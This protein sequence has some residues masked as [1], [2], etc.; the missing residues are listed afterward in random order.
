MMFTRLGA[1]DTTERRNADT[2]VEM[3]SGQPQAILRAGCRGIQRVSRGAMYLAALAGKAQR[4][5]T[6]MRGAFTHI[7]I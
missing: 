5:A 2:R 7:R 6:Q 3:G 4:D 1:S